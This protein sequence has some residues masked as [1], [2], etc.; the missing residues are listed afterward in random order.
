MMAFSRCFKKFIDLKKLSSKTANSKED[1]NIVSVKSDY[2]SHHLG[3]IKQKSSS[4]VCKA[5]GIFSAG[6]MGALAPSILKHRLLA[7]ILAK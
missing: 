2:S 3:K 1:S 5:R 6:A 7:S 4:L